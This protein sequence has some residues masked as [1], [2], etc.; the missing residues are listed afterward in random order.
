MRTIER[1]FVSALLAL[2]P[3]ACGG[4]GSSIPSAED[5]ATPDYEKAEQGKADTSV[6]AVILDFEFDGELSVIYA[7]EN[8]AQS[9]IEDQLLYT[10]GHLNGDRSVGRLDRLQL[11][12]IQISEA[13]DGNTK[14]SYHAKL[15]VAWGNKTS[16]PKTYTFVLP[17]TMSLDGQQAF[18]DKYKDRCVDFSAHDVTWEDMFYYYR[19]ANEQCHIDAADVV[20]L[21][22][23][24]A[25]ST[26]NTTGKYPEYHKIWEDN[27]LNVVVVF[28]KY[29]DGAT[30]SN[31]G[32]I[33]AYNSF[34]YGAQNALRQYDVTTTPSELPPGPGISAPDIEIK[35]SL[36]G[37]KSVQINALLVDH[38]AQAPKA[39]FD[40][41]EGLSTRADLIVY[42][43]HAGLGANVKALASKGKWTSG[44]YLIMFMNGCDT[45]AYVDGSMAETRAPLNPDDPTGTKYMDI[46]TNA[47]PA[48]F[49]Q[50]SP[51]TIALIR[52]L[53]KYEVPVTYEQIF[54][55][56]DSKQVV[57]VSGEE[58]NV[59]HPGY[60]PNEP[61]PV[62]GDWP[63]LDDSATVAPGEEK[64]WETPS[65]PT[66]SYEFAITG[67]G[68][69][70]LYV[71]I[72]M[73]PSAK[74]FDCRPYKSGS[75]ETCDVDLTS[76]GPVHLMVRG[77]GDSSD[78][79]LTG[80]KR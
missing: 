4:A 60:G 20:K 55:E 12:N 29:E 70:D 42:N 50:D 22:A 66:G 9:I 38:V 74:F 17:R 34:V 6:E 10:I 44:Q 27:A 18:T 32:G 47:M 51:A 71:R 15:P 73:A 57:L 30:T 21:T 59:Y 53:T 24:V 36:G 56:I 72:G 35:A 65:L 45:Y 41:Y 5:N 77:F 52:A 69:A 78:F 1:T 19:P 64:R 31:D 80:K 2:C 37:G 8:T 14:V 7:S 46:V 54:R 43:G 61:P 25:V 58:D 26:V 33:A 68:D 62:T 28:G 49:G 79:H 63:G 67:S 48:F 76:P 16:I 3:L 13:P 23:S 39:F 40:R 75:N 11:S